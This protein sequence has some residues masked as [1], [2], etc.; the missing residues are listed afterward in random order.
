MKN[1]EKERI[2]LNK[3]RFEVKLKGMRKK[4]GKG[5]RLWLDNDK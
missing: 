2:T 4:E 1:H 5:L 3:V